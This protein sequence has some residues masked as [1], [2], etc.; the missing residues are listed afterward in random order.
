MATSGSLTTSGGFE[1]RNFLFSWTQKSQDVEGNTTTISWEI[2]G[3]GG[4]TSL[5]YM[6]G[7][8]VASINGSVIY[9][10]TTRVKLTTRA[11]VASGTFVVAHNRV[12]EGS[13]SVEV[14]GAIYYTTM[15][16]IGAKTWTLTPIPRASVP[17]L[18]E[19]PTELGSTVVISCN[20]VVNTYKHNLYY[21]WY[22][23]TN[24]APTWEPIA[25]GVTTS[26]LWD[27]P[28][29]FASNLPGTTEG[30]GTIRCETWSGST[31]VGT[32]DIPFKATVPESYRPTISIMAAD[33]TGY[34]EIYGAL[35]QGVST[36]DVYIEPTLSYGSPIVKSLTFA[37]GGIYGDLEF[38]TDVVQDAGQTEIVAQ[39]TDERGRDSV[40][41]NETFEVLPYERPSVT[42]LSVH[43]CDANGTENDQGEYISV[44]FSARVYDLNGQ[45]SA[46]YKIL[47]TPE[48]GSP[49]TVSLTALSGTYD[50]NGYTHP[51]LAADGSKTYTVE[52]LVEDDLFEGTRSTSVSTAFTVMNWGPDGTSMAIG[53][54]AEKP[55]T[56]EVAL[57]MDVSG[58]ADFSGGLHADNADAN[59]LEVT[60]HLVASGDATFQGAVFNGQVNFAGPVTGVLPDTVDRVVERGTEAMGTNGTWYWEKWMSGVAV[61]YGKRNF[62]RAA[63]TTAWGS[64]FISSQY[65][66]TLP[67]NL[68]SSAPTY[69]S[70]QL[71]YGGGGSAWIMR[72]D[73]ED[74]NTIINTFQFVRAT[75]TTL[76][77]S[78]VYF[79]VVGRWK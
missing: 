23:T 30:T 33:P 62:G 14:E 25:L 9:S 75:S 71:G 72:G 10:S 66:Q 57:D 65:T 27:V 11:A 54:V 38:S 7:P 76:A 41:T 32:K 78:H 59:T 28:P 70:L 79:H 35:V 5:Y 49:K 73:N 64:L 29:T 17:T 40:V 67:T 63:I 20:A 4:D 55:G 13:L 22:A 50:V 45:N 21:N 53:K 34:R 37:N 61:C 18:S 46:K 74:L 15:N 19:N 48:G 68:F 36:M 60:D 12:G 1:G 8:I 2:K 24:G 43:R 58:A 44:S 26:I 16:S 3:T 31:L 39:V 6:A 47:Y 42:A 77:S 51:A 69:V 52:V 56:L